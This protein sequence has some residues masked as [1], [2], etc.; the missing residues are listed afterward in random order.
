MQQQD[1]FYDIIS[2]PMGDILMVCT[3]E[4]LKKIAFAEPNGMLYV[5]DY[6]IKDS[7][8]LKEVSRQLKA[9]FGKE[10]QQFD[11]PLAPAGSVFQHKV[12]EEVQN[13]PYGTT[14][15]YR[16]I[17]QNIDNP[18]SVRAVGMANAQN[19]IPIII[20]CHRVVGKNGN[21]VGYSA[22]L[23]KKIALLQLEGVI[24][25]SAIQTKLF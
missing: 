23:D 6:W 12:W 15:A 22:G 4:G 19:P 24:T 11:L 17:A 14:M 5:A 18:N 9:Y 20:P 10:L 8:K 25:N 2:S 7:S 21:L 13:I 3:D 16:N 1:Y